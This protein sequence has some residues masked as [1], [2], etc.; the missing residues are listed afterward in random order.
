MGSMLLSEIEFK[1]VFNESFRQKTL[2]CFPKK[3]SM[4]SL[5]ISLLFRPS[6]PNAIKQAVISIDRLPRISC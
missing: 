6:V 5:L 2:F 3:A 4:P 1:N